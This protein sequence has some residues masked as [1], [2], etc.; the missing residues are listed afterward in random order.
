M[1]IRPSTFQVRNVVDKAAHDLQPNAVVI[2]PAFPT[3][4]YWRV[5]VVY[6][7]VRIRSGL[8]F[9]VEVFDERNTRVARSWAGEIVLEP[10]YSGTEIPLT[11]FTVA[12]PQ[13]YTVRVSVNDVNLPEQ[14][15]TMKGNQ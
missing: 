1:A 12:A 14:R 6:E 11:D 15:F 5:G 2:V 3:I 10:D 9:V 8:N 13:V 4:L 7:R